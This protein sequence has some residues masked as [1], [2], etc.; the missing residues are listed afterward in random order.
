MSCQNCG[1]NFVAGLFIGVFVAVLGFI[2][3]IGNKA[4]SVWDDTGEIVI[5]ANKEYYKLTKATDEEIIKY[6]KENK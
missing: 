3:T 2:L 6:I 5:K 4:Y 1:D